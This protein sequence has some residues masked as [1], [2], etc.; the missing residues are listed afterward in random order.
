MSE[1]RRR[2]YAIDCGIWYSV[3]S[4]KMNQL[5]SFTCEQVVCQST[6]LSGLPKPPCSG[7]VKRLTAVCPNPSRRAF[8]ASANVLTI[9]IQQFWNTLVQDAKTV[10]Y[11]FQ[12]NEQWFTLNA[13][14]LHKALEITLVDSTHPFESPPAR[15]QCLTG[16]T[17]SN[18]KPRYYVLQILW[19]IVTRTNVDYDE[20]LWEEHNIH[21]R[22]VSHVHVTGDDFLLGNLK[23]VPKGEN[24]EVFGQPIPQELI[25]EAIQKSPYYQQYLEMAARKP[26]AKEG[27]KKKTASKADK[28]KKPIPAK[29]PT[30]VKQTKHVKEKTSKPSPSKKIHKGKVIKVRKGKRSDHLVNKED[31]ESQ[32]AFEPQVKDDEYNLQ[33]GIQ[34]SL[35]SFQAPV[36][37]VADDTSTNVVCDTSSPADV[38][39]SADTKKS[40]KR[41]VELDKGQAGLVPGKSSESRPPPERVHME[42]DYT[43]LNP[44]QSHVVLTRPN[45]E[46]MHKDF[47]ATVYPQVHESLKLCLPSSL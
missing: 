32:L 12:L 3:V 24:D 14:L 23:F 16:K 20:L 37:G 42:E 17:S 22:S 47:I 1:A 44:G 45:L 28:P 13:D 7:L 25:T 4:S 33:R 5:Y 39:T 19:G 11:N 27:G 10:V 35:E 36:S 30:L 26:T 8:T 41:T 6:L 38:K 31:E 43:G 15:E 21:T 9:Y 2:A 29:Q 46:P 40:N 18:D 34:M